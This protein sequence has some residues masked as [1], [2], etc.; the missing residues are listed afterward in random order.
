[1][2][3]GG[4]GSK[5]L[6]SEEAFF[7]E[8]VEMDEDSDDGFDYLEVAVDSGD[9]LQEEEIDEDLESALES[10]KRKIKPGHGNEDP[11]AGKVHP[12]MA[13]RPEV[14]DDFIRNF[15][16]KM[17]LEKT[18]EAF[19][20]EW[21]ELTQKGI[22]TE[23][24]VGV[25]PD[26]Y[27]RNQQMDDNVK[28]LRTELDKARKIAEHAESMFDNLRKERDFHRM[29]HKRVVQE[30]NTLVKDLRR[31]RDHYK[32][33][34][35]A[36][37]ETKE[38]Y[39]RLMREKS[40][41]KLDRDK[42]A[43][44]L[45]SMEQ[46]LNAITLKGKDTEASKA[47]TKKSRPQTMMNQDSQFPIDDRPNPWLNRAVPPM[48]CDTMQMGK[49]YEG[50]KLAVTDVKMHPKKNISAT[51]SDDGTWMLWALPSGELIIKGEGHKDWIA[52]C[53]FHPRGSHLATASGDST[54]KLWDFAKTACAATF[55][56]HTQAVWDVAFHDQ[57]DFCVSASMDHTVK[58]WDLNS[59][60]CRQ[61]LRG[62]VDS[63]NSVCFQ[64]FSNNVATCSG[65]KTVSLWDARTGL[66][67]QTFYGHMNA[68]NSVAFNNRG[69]C[70]VSSDADGVVKLWDIRMV[71]ERLHIETGEHAVNAA[72][73]EPSG[74]MIAVA[75][76]EGVIKMYNC[77]EEGKQVGVLRGH[78]D[79]VQAVCFDSEGTHMLSAGSDATFRMWS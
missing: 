47:S 34:E 63:V 24:D 77:E 54:V 22:L 67:M 9:E 15:L 29:H 28:Y 75:T 36:L 31:L 59:L 46:Q 58:L 70:V 57:G 68:C 79:S 48:K 61:T 45:S 76:D 6:E 18:L 51:T 13:K 73:F 23:E 44:K 65:D 69:D 40:M 11:G 17:K 37:Q 10:I 25:V 64:P 66:C 78:T 50:H 55:T 21:Y 30:K 39:D 2:S 32:H 41:L 1:M 12:V 5:G 27:L 33:F 56:E 4:D 20:A 53:D 60:R 35:P 43:T 14:L 8:K 7:L 38:K 52:A 19:Q 71:H 72:K 26:I 42:I 62:H 3:K 16:I 74:T 49:T